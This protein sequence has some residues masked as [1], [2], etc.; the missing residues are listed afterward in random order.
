MF[1]RKT[2][3]SIIADIEKRV[4]DLHDVKEAWHTE[5]EAHVAAVEASTKRG[6]KALEERDRAHRIAEKLTGLIS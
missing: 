6:F 4:S 1:F 3:D 5:Y 2:V